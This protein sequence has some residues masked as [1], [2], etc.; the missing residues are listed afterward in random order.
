MS[1]RKPLVLNPEL[2][3]KVRRDLNVGEDNLRLNL[4]PEEREAAQKAEAVTDP[5]IPPISP[6]GVPVISGSAVFLKVAAA[7][8]GIAWIVSVSDF[9]PATNLDEKIAGGVLTLG[10]LLGIASPGIRKAS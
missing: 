9:F 5:M 1:D 3:A 6:T 8:I 2:A 4:T 7:I 10:A